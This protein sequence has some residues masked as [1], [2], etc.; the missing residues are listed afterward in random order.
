MK[1]VQNQ[2]KTWAVVDEKGK[3]RVSGLKTRAEA[4]A[5]VKAFLGEPRELGLEVEPVP[6]TPVEEPPIVE[7]VVESPV[8]AP[9]KTEAAEVADVHPGPVALTVHN[10]YEL[11]RAVSSKMGR[12]TE[13]FT[14]KGLTVGQ[15]NVLKALRPNKPKT[16]KD[17]CAAV[18]C[19]GGNMTM[20]IDNLERDGFVKRTQDERDRRRVVVNLTDDGAILANQASQAGPK[21]ENGLFNPILGMSEEKVQAFAE[22]LSVLAR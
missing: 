10:L 5:K 9:K 20:I 6:Q 21:I 14:P 2:N 12:L 8:A 19:S 7:E 1:A 13:E 11:L 4:R 18:G 22:V 3:V 15:S 17:L 16:Q